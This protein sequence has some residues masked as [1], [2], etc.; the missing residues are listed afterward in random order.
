MYAMRGI[1]NFLKYRYKIQHG[2]RCITFSGLKMN[3]C[4][5]KSKAKHIIMMC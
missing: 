4:T 2:I 3:Q 1:N 5:Q